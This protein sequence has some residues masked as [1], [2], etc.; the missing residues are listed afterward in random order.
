MSQSCVRMP[1]TVSMILET[2]SKITNQQDRQ[3]ALSIAANLSKIDC[4]GSRDIVLRM[5]EYTLSCPEDLQAIAYMLR[6]EESK[7]E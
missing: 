4:K 3:H 7:R 5:A 6:D 2:M 1:E